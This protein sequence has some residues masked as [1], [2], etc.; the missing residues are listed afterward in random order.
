VKLRSTPQARSSAG[1]HEAGRGGRLGGAHRVLHPQ[2]AVV[3]HRRQVGE[4]VGAQALHPA[5]LVVDADQQVLAD[6]LD[7]G[8]QRGELG[9]VLPVA[10]EQDQPAGQR[11]GQ[12][13]AVVGA[14]RGAGDVEDDGA[15]VVHGDKDAGRRQRFRRRRS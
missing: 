11:M 6:G 3:A 9:P 14:Q 15:V 12:A 4:A 10:G 13:A 8:D 2:L 7:L 1:Q 5:A